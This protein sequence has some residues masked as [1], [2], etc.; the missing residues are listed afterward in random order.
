MPLSWRKPKKHLYQYP[1]HYTLQ[2]ESNS[3]FENKP[4]WCLLLVPSWKLYL[5]LRL[6]VHSPLRHPTAPSWCSHWKSTYLGCRKLLT[7]GPCSSVHID[8][9]RLLIWTPLPPALQPFLT[10]SSASIY[11]NRPS[12]CMVDVA[13]LVLLSLLCPF[14]HLLNYLIIYMPVYCLP[15][16][17]KVQASKG[18][19]ALSVFFQNLCIQGSLTASK[20]SILFIKKELKE[21]PLNGKD[22]MWWTRK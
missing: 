11:C 22:Y 7:L 10:S 2:H 21:W 20:F 3:D 14:G 12:S 6:K 1:K 8:W 4:W 13:Y 5:L 19:E 9:G 15:V 18:Q 17:T 16:F